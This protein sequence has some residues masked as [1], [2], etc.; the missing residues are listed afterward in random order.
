MKSDSDNFDSL[1]TK[2]EIGSLE[3][4][5]SPLWSLYNNNTHSH[6][7]MHNLKSREV[8]GKTICVNRWRGKNG[9]INKTW[10][11][12]IDRWQDA[13]LLVC[14]SLSGTQSVMPWSN[15][16]GYTLLFSLHPLCLY[17]TKKHTVSVT[18]MNFEPLF[19]FKNFSH[20]HKYI[21]GTYKK[22]K[23]QCI[24]ISLFFLFPYNDSKTHP[25]SFSELI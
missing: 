9:K 7:A 15:A 22:K 14:L 23:T 4:S 13:P 11:G 8:E 20:L 5:L 19:A 16:H 3:A 18:R 10:R 24:T 6:W 2:R 25:Q 12:E 17:L 1:K 21:L